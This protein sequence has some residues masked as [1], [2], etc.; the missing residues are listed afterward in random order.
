M[1]PIDLQ[2]AEVERELKLRARVF[3][4]Q[5]SKGTITQSA[6]DK[7]MANMEAVLE[8]LKLVRQKEILI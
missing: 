6:A 3:P 8:T 4:R 2:I 1:I 7:H 5:V